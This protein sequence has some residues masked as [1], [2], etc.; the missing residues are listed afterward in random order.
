MVH[1]RVQMEIS[2]EGSCYSWAMH[3]RLALVLASNCLSVVHRIYRW[4]HIFGTNPE[5][6]RRRD[7]RAIT[8]QRWCQIV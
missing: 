4:H 6:T 5:A 8:K 2:G 7:C 1:P 3:V